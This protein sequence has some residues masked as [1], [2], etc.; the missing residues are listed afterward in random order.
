MN[1]DLLC[2]KVLQVYQTC[3]VH[4]FPIDCFAL[5]EHYGLRTVTYQ[6]T[7]EKNPAL[8]EAIS[9]YSKDAF[10]FRST[11]YYNTLQNHGRIRFSLMHELA[12]HILGHKNDCDRSDEREAD[13]FASYLLAPRPVIEFEDLH[14]AEE[15]RD[16]F[17]I[18]ITAANIAIRDFRRWLYHCPQTNDLLLLNYLYPNRYRRDG[19]IR[20]L[21]INSVNYML[22]YDK[23]LDGDE[24]EIPDWFFCDIHGN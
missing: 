18:S 6:E 1:S 20:Y 21:V 8:F 22:P 2:E 5:L 16:F 9:G 19:C 7:Q 23:E 4:R 11:V 10:T 17:Q 24:D 13:Q 15:V 12:H 3:H 14:T